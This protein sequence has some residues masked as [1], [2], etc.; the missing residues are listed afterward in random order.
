MF[1][2]F[3]LLIVMLF[4]SN[5]NHFASC[6]R[7]EQKWPFLGLQGKQLIIILYQIFDRNDSFFHGEKISTNL[8][9]QIFFSLSL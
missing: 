9:L 4:L 3:L 2:G 5:K 6:W 8:S 7:Y 1:L